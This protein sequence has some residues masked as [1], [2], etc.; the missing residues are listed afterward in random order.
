[1]TYVRDSRWLPYS[2]EMGQKE[3]HTQNVRE[4]AALDAD[5]AE[6]EV[7]IDDDEAWEARGGAWEQIG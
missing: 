2:R 6:L 5:L 7:E 4:L 3:L 1:M